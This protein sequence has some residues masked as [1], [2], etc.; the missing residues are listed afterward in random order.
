M[1]YII[2]YAAMCRQVKFNIAR[3]ANAREFDWMTISGRGPASLLSDLNG[4]YIYIY[5]MCVCVCVCDITVVVVVVVVVIIIM[6]MYIRVHEYLLL[7]RERGY[8]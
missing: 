1:I 8:C 4:V 3:P 5:N 7:E 6:Y 2:I